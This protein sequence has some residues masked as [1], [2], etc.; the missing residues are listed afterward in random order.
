MGLELFG[1]ER[2]RMDNVTGV[3]IP[4]VL[5]DGEQIRAQLLEDFSLEIGTSFGPL[6][7]KIWRIGT[8]GYV[9]Q[10]SNILCCLSSLENVLSRTPR[11][12]EPK[13]S[14][15]APNRSVNVP[16]IISRSTAYLVVRRKY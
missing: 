12:L 11:L 16:S 2:Y 8:M 4:N 3:L 5:G 10:K 6:K 15:R 1:D 9:C 13:N 14:Q 7:G